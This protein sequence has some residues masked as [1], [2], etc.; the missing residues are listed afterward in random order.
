M[1]T[2]MICGRSS[3]PSESRYGR[4]TIR[5]GDAAEATDQAHDRGFGQHDAG[6]GATAGAER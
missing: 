6:D 3:T 5:E 1:R 2:V 4:P